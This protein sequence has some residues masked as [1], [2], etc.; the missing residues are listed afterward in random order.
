MF[1]DAEH[2]EPQTSLSIKLTVAMPNALTR[3]VGLNAGTWVL[4]TL[5]KHYFSNVFKPAD[6]NITAEETGN[7][8]KEGSNANLRREEILYDE[9]F[10][11]VKVCVISR[12]DLVWPLMSLTH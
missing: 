8:R 5:V 9:A 7:D 10:H 4:E 1:E 2:V 11:I 6:G 3:H 12:L